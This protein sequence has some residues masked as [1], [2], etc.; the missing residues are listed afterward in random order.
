MRLNAFG[1]TVLVV[2]V[3]L[4]MIWWRAPRARIA[5]ASVINLEKSKE[6]LAQFKAAA[7]VAGLDVE[8][9]PAFDGRTLEKKDIYKHN[10]S[11]LIWRHTQATRKLGVIG[12][13]LSHKQLLASLESRHAGS[14]DVH[15][16]FEDDAVV[17]ADFKAQLERIV[18]QLPTDWDVI[19]LGVTLPRTVPWSK[20]RMGG[21]IHVPNG[22]MYG[23]D[24]CFAYAVRHGALRKINAHLKYMNDPIDTQLKKKNKEW[25][26]FIMQPM[27]VPTQDGGKSTLPDN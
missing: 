8:R 27:L 1:F 7:A 25:K 15:L 11:E 3:V 4:L 19:Q 6:R 2:L 12:C 9:W 18:C 5:S 17:P 16:I 22:G 26:W 14:A 23:N 24:G 10:I 20:Q 21:D 13:W